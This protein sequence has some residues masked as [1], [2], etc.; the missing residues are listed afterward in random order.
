MD[1]HDADRILAYGSHLGV[2]STSQQDKWHRWSSKHMG[3][4][5]HKIGTARVYLLTG[6]EMAG[7]EKKS[8]SLR[9]CFSPILHVFQE[10]MLP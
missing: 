6:G 8:Q 4:W 9:Q 1:Q 7:F 10:G 2:I 3:F 5:P